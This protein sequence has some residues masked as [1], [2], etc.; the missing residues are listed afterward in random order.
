MA[1]GLGRDV[2][3][4]RFENLVGPATRLGSLFPA[5]LPPDPGPRASGVQFRLLFRPPHGLRDER[6][7]PG[8]LDLLSVL[9]GFVSGVASAF[10]NLHRLEHFRG[11]NLLDFVFLVRGTRYRVVLPFRVQSGAEDPAGFES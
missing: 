6:S 3:P 9:F 2:R 10:A 11:R 1:L 8:L 5:T 7:S 4:G